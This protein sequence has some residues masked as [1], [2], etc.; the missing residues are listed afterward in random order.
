M[1]DKLSRIFELKRTTLDAPSI[2]STTGSFEQE[3]LFVEINE[4]LIRVTEGKSY[5]RVLGTLTVFAQFDKLPYGY[6][7]KRIQQS[8]HSLTKDFFFFDVDLNPAN[9]PAR[10]Q[11]IAERRLR[12]VYLYAAQ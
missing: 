5:A 11:N 7:N 12:F 6:F 8:D 10:F 1:L 3:T 9:S 2:N 4:T